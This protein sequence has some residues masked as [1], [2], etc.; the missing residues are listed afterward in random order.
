MILR[1]RGIELLTLGIGGYFQVEELRDL[2][3]GPGL[4]H[5]YQTA[6]F[7]TLLD[8]ATEV[9]DAICNS[10]CLVCVEYGTV[11]NMKYI[12]RVPTA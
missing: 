12:I 6:N 7:T 9:V 8:T 2:A 10:R 1:S 4:S 11:Y 3:S 5:I